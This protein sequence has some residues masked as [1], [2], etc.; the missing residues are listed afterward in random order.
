MS[1]IKNK[2]KSFTTHSGDCSELNNLEN[3]VTK[4]RKIRAV[5][6]SHRNENEE[7]LRILDLGCSYGIILKE[8]SDVAC[9]SVGVDLDVNA[10]KNGAVPSTSVCSDAEVL[11]F[12]D[13]SF[14][15]V[16]CNHVYEHTEDAF[17]LVEE[18]HRILDYSGLCYFAGPNKYSLVEPHYE[19]PVLSWLPQVI[20]NKYIKLFKGITTYD[21]KPFSYP[22][23][24]KLIGKFNSTEYT[25]QVIKYPARF[26]ADSM[27]PQGSLKQKIA[28]I[29]YKYLK[30][31]FPDFIFILYKNN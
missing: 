8:F 6:Q 15:L 2:A 21:V 12:K 22:K 16:I 28:L 3:R 19:L 26:H 13:S 30:W 29:A 11:P 1:S 31:I 17:K 7:R 10:L 4:A 23:L 5:I 18:I 14:D 9:M 20:A 25:E 24:I 27:I